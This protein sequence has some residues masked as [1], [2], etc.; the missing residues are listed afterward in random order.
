MGSSVPNLLLYTLAFP[1]PPQKI[2]LHSS[3][4]EHSTWYPFPGHQ[5]VFVL[6]S[7]CIEVDSGWC[8]LDESVT[9]VFCF[10]FPH[11]WKN[12]F[13]NGKKFRKQG[14]EGGGRDTKKQITLM[15]PGSTGKSQSPVAVRKHERDARTG[16]VYVILPHVHSRYYPTRDT[17]AVSVPG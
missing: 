14:V 6:A 4:G 16:Q 3:Q 13:K 10:V 9:T 17:M 12:Y 5:D 1:F 15:S 11:V 7:T 8:Q 2:L